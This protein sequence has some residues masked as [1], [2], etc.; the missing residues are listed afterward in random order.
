MTKMPRIFDLVVL[1]HDPGATIYRVKELGDHSVGI[2]DA[3]IERLQ[4]KQRVQ[5][6]DL[7]L[8]MQ[9]SLAQLAAIAEEKL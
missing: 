7:S 5:W 6:V 2:I 4:P 9:P 3:T 1:S 8:V